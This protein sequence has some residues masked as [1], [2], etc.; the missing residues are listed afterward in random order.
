VKAQ[1]YIRGV[2]SVVLILAVQPQVQASNLANFLV[3]KPAM[4]QSS[5]MTLPF[6]GEIPLLTKLH[7]AAMPVKAA[8]GNSSSGSPA[9]STRLQTPE[10]AP[11][12]P[13]NSQSQQTP[14]MVKPSQSSTLLPDGQIL[15]LGGFGADHKP[16]ADAYLVD[17]TGKA[18]KIAAQLHAP[19]AGHTATV[20]PDGA[21]LVFGGVNPSGDVVSAAE[22][23][24]PVARSFSP[25]STR[26]VPRAFH[27]AT[28]LTDGT[29]L[30]AGGVEQ[31]HV[32]P[33]DV[34]KWD[35][36]TGQVTTFDALLSV[37][38]EGHNAT[39][40]SDGTVRLSGGTDLFG[41][42]VDVDEIFDPIVNRFRS[43]APNEASIEDA[44]PARVAASIPEDGASGVDVQGIVAVRLTVPLDVT[45]VSSASF[46]LMGPDGVPVT[47]KVTAAEQGRLVFV[48]PAAA[49]QTGTT[50]TLQIQKAT[51]THGN[52]ILESSITFTTEGEISS[53][54]S[55][56][57]DN[58]G[59]TTT[60][61]QS[62]PPLQSTAGDTALSGQVLKLNGW[63]LNT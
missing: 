46:T 60:K 50:Y 55:Q 24:D 45:S 40:L 37:P 27:S 10:P 32:F 16:V 13:A 61:F 26:L 22:I 18:Q 25:V 53:G 49:L 36:R 41:R 19:R 6:A 1:A 29:L 7:G 47:A 15:L 59:P 38:R 11:A 44:G 51:D 39:L 43:A 34:Q 9:L 62:M 20:L 58:G 2:V 54:S 31:N 4:V 48:L 23:F 52:A 35:Y 63:P 3:S 17:R 57:S 33:A 42:P 12:P 8:A 30:I 21:V 28:L 14:S 56:G 5:P